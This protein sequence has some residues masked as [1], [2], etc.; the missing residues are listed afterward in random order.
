MSALTLGHRHIHM[1]GPEYGLQRVAAPGAQLVAENARWVWRRAGRQG[2]PAAATFPVAVKPFC[3][4][5][6]TCNRAMAD[7][8]RPQ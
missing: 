3:Y 7:T 1:L 8:F 4:H 2:G 5:Q 6:Q